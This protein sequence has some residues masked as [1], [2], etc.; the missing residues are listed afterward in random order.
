[1]LRFLLETV[2]MIAESASISLTSEQLK[3]I[4]EN[5]MQNDELWET[6]DNYVID[7]IVSAVKKG[8]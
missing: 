1:M 7:E 4:I 2:T 3:T 5:L 6:V 8:E